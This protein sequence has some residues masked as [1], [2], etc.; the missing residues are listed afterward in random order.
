[1]MPG[2]M[3][4][5]L[6]NIAQFPAGKWPNLTPTETLPGRQHQSAPP[7]AV[8]QDKAMTGSYGGKFPQTFE[9]LPDK[10]PRTLLETVRHGVAAGAAGGLAEIAW[11]TLYAGATGTDPSTLARGV[12]TAAGVSALF[13]SASAA[14]GVTIH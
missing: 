8:E 5:P 3:S 12:T 11:V 6:V 14:V 13:P 7:A 4:P 9:Q 10:Q 2:T 1:M